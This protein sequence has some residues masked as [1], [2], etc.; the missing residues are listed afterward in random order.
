M[1]PVLAIKSATINTA[2]EIGVSHIRR[3]S[4]GYTADMVLTKDIHT[5]WADAVFYGGKLVAEHGKLTVEI[6]D[7]EYEMETRNSMNAGMCHWMT[8]S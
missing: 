7:R 2:R 8:L 1:D 4:A 6:E 5:M 3:S